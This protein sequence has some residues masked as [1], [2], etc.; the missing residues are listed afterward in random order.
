MIANQGIQSSAPIIRQRHQ[1]DI[2]VHKS[3]TEG[4]VES[5]PNMGSNLDF[6]HAQPASQREGARGVGDSLY[7]VCLATCKK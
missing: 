3:T 6:E 1:R 7:F 4:D 2:L 5:V